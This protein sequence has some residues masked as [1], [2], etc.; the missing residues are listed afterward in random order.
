MA[1][2]SDTDVTWLPSVCPREATALDTAVAAEVPV[3]DAALLAALV[4]ARP[5]SMGP[6]QCSIT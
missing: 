2:T 4:P 5:W 6:A 3:L 1:L